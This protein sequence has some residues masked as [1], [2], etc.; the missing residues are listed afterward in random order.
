M[1]AEGWRGP[2]ESPVTALDSSGSLGGNVEE[3]KSQRI[4]LGVAVVIITAPLWGVSG[5]EGEEVASY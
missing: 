3:V 4:S 5:V 1:S 2:D